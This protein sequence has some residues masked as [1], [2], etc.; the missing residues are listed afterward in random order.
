MSTKLNKEE[1]INL[2]KKIGVQ[3]KSANIVDAGIVRETKVKSDIFGKKIEIDCVID[4]PAVHIRKKLEDDINEVLS[5]VYPDGVEIKTNVKV[6]IPESEKEKPLKKI[7][8]IIAVA[9]G[10]GGVGKSTVTANLAVTLAKMGFAVGILDTDVYGPSIPIMFNTQN[11]R[12]R[13]LKNGDKTMIIPIESYGVKNMSMGY[14]AQ[15]GQ[16]VI[17]RGSMANSAINQMVFDTNWGDLDFLLIDLPPGT[18]DIQ[19]SVMQTLP[20]TGAVV[21]TTP[22]NVAVA[23]VVKSIDMFKNPTINVPVLGIV[24]NMSYFTPEE[25]PDNKY[26]IFGKDGGKNLAQDIDVAYLG[27]VPLVQS[28]REAGDVGRPAAM[29][30]NSPI[31][32]AFEAITKNVVTETMN[33]NKTL[34]PTEKIRISDQAGCS[35]K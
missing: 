14:F 28:V 32:D 22:Q 15:P 16:A 34:P 1:V 7:K 26:Y 19:L 10:K 11:E 5:N 30:E 18:G 13:A 24:E 27:G 21:V 33:R 12:P 17:W 9:S 8:N 23:D 6:V 3:G 2:L 35:V 29:Q 4:S 20:V 31:A 25:C